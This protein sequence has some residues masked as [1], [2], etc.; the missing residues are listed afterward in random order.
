MCS[1]IT[2]GNCCCACSYFWSV[3]LASFCIQR[4]RGYKEIPR[5]SYNCSPSRI[6]SLVF[7]NYKIWYYPSSILASYCSNMGLCWHPMDLLSHISHVP[8]V[9]ILDNN[10]WVFFDWVDAEPI[11]SSLQKQR[12]NALLVDAESFSRI[13]QIGAP[14]R[15]IPDSYVKS[16]GELI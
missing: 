1:C 4:G 16:S 2:H 6:L 13:C 10:P 5:V 7:P 14:K 8:W 3:P 9:C 12:W 11:R 15:C